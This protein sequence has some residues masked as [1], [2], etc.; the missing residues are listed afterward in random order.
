[1]EFAWGLGSGF[2]RGWQAIPPRPSSVAVNFTIRQTEIVR[3][4]RFFCIFCFSVPLICAK[5]R[6]NERL[7]MILDYALEKFPFSAELR[8]GTAVVVR[9]L[10]KRDAGRLHKFFLAVPEEER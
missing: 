4:T 9:P 8:D 10:A 1:M 5:D 7:I 6:A 2:R 3:N